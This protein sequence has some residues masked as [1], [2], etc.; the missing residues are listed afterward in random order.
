LVD[1]IHNKSFKRSISYF[2]G[3][4]LYHMAVPATK[5]LTVVSR[6]C[7]WLS[8]VTCLKLILYGALLANKQC[9]ILTNVLIIDF[10]WSYDESLAGISHTDW[11]KKI[12]A[13]HFDSWWRFLT[14]HFSVIITENSFHYKDYLNFFNVLSYYYWVSYWWVI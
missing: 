11:E 9:K 3:L 13:M 7:V 6:R 1:K 12:S 5:G 8:P 4:L 14:S 2:H 10:D